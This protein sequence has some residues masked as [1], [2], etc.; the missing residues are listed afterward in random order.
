ML[1]GNWVKT[2]RCSYDELYDPLRLTMLSGNGAQ[3]KRLVDCTEQWC[4]HCL[5]GFTYR[6]LITLRLAGVSLSKWMINFSDWSTLLC[7]DDPALGCCAGDCGGVSQVCGSKSCHAPDLHS[8]QAPPHLFKMS[9]R[10]S[11]SL[12]SYPDSRAFWFF[13]WA[14][15]TTRRDSHAR[16]H[17]DTTDKTDVRCLSLSLYRGY[18][19]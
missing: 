12:W 2:L 15:D 10:P 3:V 14:H 16:T 17:P 11:R 18:S 5:Q 13:R 7:C 1:S 19:F 9:A 8:N 6:R 4:R